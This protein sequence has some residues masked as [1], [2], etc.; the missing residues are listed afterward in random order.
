MKHDDRRSHGIRR[1]R[2][3][4]LVVDAHEPHA[5]A[6]SHRLHTCFTIV[7]ERCAHAREIRAEA[8]ELTELR[9]TK[10]LRR[11][12]DVDRLEQVRLALPVVARDDVEALSRL[13]IYRAEIAERP[14]LQL[15][16]RERAMKRAQLRSAWA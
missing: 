3:R 4:T 9:S 10:A 15:S 13:E 1:K 8:D 14:D 5:G 12:G 6:N 2:R 16:Q 7:V 11:G